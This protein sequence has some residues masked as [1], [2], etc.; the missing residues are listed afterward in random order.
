MNRLRCSKC[1]RFISDQADSYIPF[2]NYW[3]DEPEIKLM[4]QKCVDEEIERIRRTGKIF[5][6]YSPA[7]FEW[8]LAK[9]L[10]Y[11]RVDG[12]WRKEDV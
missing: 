4:C 1:G 11:K 5:S 8:K 9:E 7:N 2:G 12:W 10:G 3:D 6:H